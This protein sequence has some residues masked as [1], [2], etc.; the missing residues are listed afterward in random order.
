MLIHVLHLQKASPTDG[1]ASMPSEHKKRKRSKLPANVRAPGVPLSALHHELLQFAAAAAPTQVLLY[2]NAMC[3]N[4]KPAL[5][6]CCNV[7]DGVPA[8]WLIVS[9]TILQ[10]KS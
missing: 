5:P 3:Q 1:S 9:R 4:A 2:T 6:L 10:S 7:T 8:P